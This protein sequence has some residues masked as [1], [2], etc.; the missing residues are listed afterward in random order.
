[1]VSKAELLRRL[2]TPQLR[3]IARKERVSIPRSATKKT[4]VK[5][6]RRYSPFMGL[7]FTEPDWIVLKDRRLDCMG[8]S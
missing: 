8:G 2:K 6:F 5:L 7:K 3:K 1:L 4:L